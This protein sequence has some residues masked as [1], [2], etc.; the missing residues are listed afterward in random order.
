MQKYITTEHT[1]NFNKAIHPVEFLYQEA[2]SK[3]VRFNVNK[4]IFK[5][6]MIDK[7]EIVTTKAGENTTMVKDVKGEESGEETV[8]ASPLVVVDQMNKDEKNI[9]N[10]ADE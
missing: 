2:S 1:N 8:R 4:G 5:G 6:W 3:D 9:D 10:R 7:D